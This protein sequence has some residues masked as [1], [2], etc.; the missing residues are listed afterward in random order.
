VQLLGEPLHS[1]LGWMGLVGLCVHVWGQPCTAV[2]AFGDWDDRRAHDGAQC[3]RGQPA[4]YGSFG[5]G[6]CRLCLLV[7]LGG[8]FGLTAGACVM[9]RGGG[10]NAGSGDRQPVV[11]AAFEKVR[12]PGLLG[13]VG[14]WVVG[15]LLGQPW[16][17]VALQSWEGA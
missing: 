12:G 6:G 14:E 9:A 1:M 15:G 17:L 3:W 8:R 16:V 7:R 4:R 2:G 11:I 10:R 13:W 5:E